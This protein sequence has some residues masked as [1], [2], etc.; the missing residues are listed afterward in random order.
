MTNFAV[1]NK[2][3]MPP[4]ET[5]PAAGTS[6]GRYRLLVE[7]ITDY[8]IYLLDPSG[9]VV[10]WNLGAERFKGYTADEIIGQNFA[11]FYSEEDRNAGVPKRN[12]A[13][14]AKEGRFEEEDWR[15]RKDGSR[16]WANVVIDRIVDPEGRLFGFAKITRDL[17]Q[18]RFQELALHKSEEQFRVFVKGVKDYALYMLDIHGNV[19]SWNAGAERIKGYRE[20][21][22]IGQNFS[23]FYPEQDRKRGEPQKNLDA[24]RIKGNVELE[25]WRV[26]KDGSSFFAQVL[27]DALYD[28][29]GDL[30]GFAKVTRDITDRRESEKQL[31]EARDA[32]F[33]SRLAVN[34]AT[35]RDKIMRAL[36]A[37]A[38]PRSTI[39][40]MSS[41]LLALAGARGFA[42]M[43]NE[44]LMSAGWVPPDTE[45]RPLAVWLEQQMGDGK[46]FVT[47]RLSEIYPAS[48]RLEADASGVLSIA[49]PVD[50][51]AL[52]IWFRPQTIEA[53]CV[54]EP[55]SR[56]DIESV[57]GFQPRLAFVLQ[58]Q[59]VREL[60]DLLGRANEQLLAL[61]ATDGLTGVANR[62]GF[63]ERLGQEWSLSTRLGTPLG[64]IILDLDF[65]KQYNDSFGHLMGDECLKRI[66]KVL[67]Q[68]HRAADF[69]ARFGGEEFAILLPDTNVEG[70]LAVAEATRSQI[71]ELRLVHPQSPY[72]VVTASVGVATALPYE[73]CTAELLVQAADE[74]LYASKKSGRNRVVSSPFAFPSALSTCAMLPIGTAGLS[75]A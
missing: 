15:Y 44:T 21:E 58:Q 14:A 70:A 33:Q 45:L 73:T 6:E 66:A 3:L 22:I 42:I 7:S 50:D 20:S 52:L 74:A 48:P 12:L 39:F 60:N 30:I 27:I 57:E 40:D 36:I 51:R 31:K 55:W 72:G 37:S 28:G 68:K 62:R 18:R 75:A 1:S 19:V 10:N 56:A 24:A 34:L 32:L 2:M 26:R 71:E 25:G 17:T 13:R 43:W 63:H 59:R 53:D 8:A 54:F 41:E 49:L 5:Y 67:S 11:K 46:M 9:A 69:V 16:F 64:L 47:N 38:D 29:M 61:A 23:Q 35:T 65:F 4:P